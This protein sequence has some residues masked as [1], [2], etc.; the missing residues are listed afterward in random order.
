MLKG[1]RKNPVPKGERE[2][3]E[4]KDCKQ[5]LKPICFVQ[6]GK[7][8]AGNIKYSVRCKKCNK[9]HKKHNHPS[10]RKQSVVIEFIQLQK[11]KCVVCSYDKLKAA[12]EFHHIDPTQKE[13]GISAAWSKSNAIEII[14]EEMKKCIIVCNRCH[15]EIHA[16]LIPE[17]LIET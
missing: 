10:F 4:C 7:T 2:T 13:F 17:Y 6:T 15:R 1:Q 3:L 12:L 5:H 11:I 16:G 9:E 14:K 8:S